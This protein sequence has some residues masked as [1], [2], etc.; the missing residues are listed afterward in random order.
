LKKRAIE[1]LDGGEFSK[2]LKDLH[3]KEVSE[4]EEGEKSNLDGRGVS[5][6][7]IDSGFDE[8]LSEF[9]DENGDSRVKCHMICRVCGRTW[10]EVEQ[11]YKNEYEVVPYNGES[12]GADNFHGNTAADLATGKKC[13][14]APKADIYFFETGDGDHKAKQETILKY[15]RDNMD[16]LNLDIISLS[17]T[18][19]ESTKDIARSI[20]GCEFVHSD[21]FWENFFPG[22]EVNRK[23]VETGEVDSEIVETGFVESIKKFVMEL[24]KQK[25]EIKENPKVKKFA[26]GDAMAIPV[27]G[28]TS[29]QALRD[30]EGN[31]SESRKFNGSLC[32]ASFAIAQVVG[33]F[34]LARQMNPTMSFENFVNKA[35][36]H[37]KVNSSNGQLFINPIEVIEKIWE[38][39]RG[40]SVQEQGQEPLQEPNN[41]PSR[42]NMTQ[43]L[44]RETIE[45]QKNTGLKIDTE[46]VIE[47]DER[48]IESTKDNTQSL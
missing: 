29:I 44:G 18:A 38:E 4:T 16:D 28:R 34:A 11:E 46:Q 40:V 17:D 23:I 19:S 7:F 47:A 21:I 25:P 39:Q 8:D 15:I 20:N 35:R 1:L 48:A 32:G 14:I 30:E 12:V 24:A 9:K 45:E 13:G 27:E 2:S 42:E 3:S 37:A 31:I 43:R 41:T 6:A 36:E 26:N 10:D 22:R 33:Y 5:I